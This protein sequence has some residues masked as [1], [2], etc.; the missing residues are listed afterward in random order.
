MSDSLK[1]KNGK[2]R[3]MYVRK[4]EEEKPRRPANP[5]ASGR[6]GRDRR[7]DAPRGEAPRRGEGRPRHDKPDDRTGRPAPRRD[8]PSTS[9]DSPW[10]TLYQN[11]ERPAEADHGGISGKS[12]IDPDQL[13]RQRAE[14]TRVYGENACQAL[15][16]SRPDSIVRAWFVQSVTPRFRDALRWMAANRK[17]YH[18]VEEEELALASGTEHHGGVC[19]L[20]KKRIGLDA[21]LY[22]QQT[23]NKDCVLALEDVSN[24]HNL[25]AIL[26]SCAHFGVRGVMTSDSAALESGA[27]VRTAEGGAEHISA[28]HTDDLINDLALF[29][30]AGYTIVTTSSHNGVALSQAKMPQKMVLV[31]G[32]ERRGLSSEIVA[33]TDMAV[34]IGGT[35]RV[36]SLN[37]SVATG[38]LLAEWWRQNNQPA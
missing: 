11:D 29:R 20:I 21:A 36:E 17:A 30:Q 18:V 15:F 33:Q 14:E 8:R 24:P 19:F 37:V 35:G 26:R 3:I 5:S 23:G 22:L 34:S 1:G 6:D 12:L 31:L 4:D 32:E 25:G 28:I 2:V 27:A 13:R 10:K 7:S 9:P 38:I 16:K